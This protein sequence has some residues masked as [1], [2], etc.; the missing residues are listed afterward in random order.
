MHKAFTIH[1]FIVV[2]GV[3]M[4]SMEIFYIGTE[5]KSAQKAAMVA[6]RQVEKT[7]MA[8]RQRIFQNKLHNE[9]ATHDNQKLVSYL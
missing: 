2:H 1:Y 9:H 4:K 5:Y 8:M 7:N 6:V 3:M